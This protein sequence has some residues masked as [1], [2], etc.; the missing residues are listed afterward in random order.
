[1]LNSINTN[2]AAYT[3]QGNIGKASNSAAASISRLSSGNRI[4]KASDDVASLSVGTSL[5]TGVTT[6]KQALA[7]TAQGSSL[8]QVADG[9]LS[10]IGDLLQR[11]KAI[12]T[13]ANS[14][15]LSDV[16][17]GYLNQEFQALKSQID[18]IASSASFSAVKLLDGSLS[19]SN[20]LQAA[21]AANTATIDG[22]TA[23][24]AN[25]TAVAFTD[26]A[27][28]TKGDTTFAG[29][30]SKGSFQVQSDGATGFRVTYTLNGSTYVGAFDDVGATG[31]SLALTNGEGTIT[32]TLAADISG[33][34]AGS[35][36]GATAFK[37]ALEDSVAGAKA[38]ASRTLAATDVEVDGKTISGSAIEA[39]DTNGTILAGITGSNVT[40]K[41]EFW[42]GANAPTISDFTASSYSTGAKFSVTV[43]GKTYTTK[44][45]ATN[46][47]DVKA[48]NIFGDGNG[49]MRFY[50]DGDAS[51]NPDEYVQVSLAGL[52]NTINVSTEE[53]TTNFV[54]ALND[55][56]GRSGGGLTLQVGALSTDTLSVSIK[57]TST[58]SL[59][60]DNDGVLQNLNV[61][62]LAGAQ[63]ASAILDNAIARVNATRADVGA[64]QSRIDFTAAN[65]QTSIQNQDAAR[66]TLLDT[67][68][69]AE[70]TAYATAQVQLQA[71]I[72]VL[73]QANQLPQNLLKLIS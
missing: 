11:Q 46:L 63:E 71:G 3:A 66:G 40:I 23:Q 48:G 62:T 28:G 33:T 2:I 10:Q 34:F 19:G 68:V 42:G 38:Y 61:T 27:T 54:G 18:Q 22:F 64:L 43:D 9:A 37:E 60:V 7:N 16:E 73:A 26:N 47:A 69:A 41:S 57:N 59:Y 14:G 72:A 12:A 65:L 17:R 29:D 39:K 55:L 13:Q 67:D 25:I 5:K 15:T 21:E 53:A 51:A 4:S 52:T 20:P 6:L 1:M 31:A 58:E 44:A 45:A 32:F 49:I 70:S 35:A 8:L 36:A 56:F 50:L 24:G 30:L